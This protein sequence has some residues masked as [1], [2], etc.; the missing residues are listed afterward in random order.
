MIEL[1][2]TCSG[3]LRKLR[4]GNNVLDKRI[5]VSLQLYLALGV[6]RA[7]HC[8]LQSARSR[9]KELYI[10]LLFVN[11]FDLALQVLLQSEVVRSQPVVL[12]FY[13]HVELNLLIGVAM[14][15]RQLLILRPQHVQLCFE[16][17]VGL[18]ELL[19]GLDDLCH[20]TFALLHL[21]LE[22]LIALGELVQLIPLLLVVELDLL[23]RAL[24][25]LD[26]AKEG[27]LVGLGLFCRLGKDMNLLLHLCKL[28]LLFLDVGLH[29]PFE[30]PI[31]EL[32]L[33]DFLFLRLD[34]NFIQL[35]LFNNLLLI[36]L[37]A[38]FELRYL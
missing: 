38:V 9:L 3:E 11:G 17:P 35:L 14:A 37:K 5:V 1:H 12:L 26:L 25:V 31:S 22:N 18:S 16:L 4:A 7:R 32:V 2:A 29:L 6:R 10:L 33:L 30:L 15:S 13:L 28:A 36:L 34:P 21:F 23:N 20:F 27:L 19:E 8:S 24:H